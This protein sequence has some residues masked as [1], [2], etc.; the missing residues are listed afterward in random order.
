MHITIIR[1]YWKEDFSI[2]YYREQLEKWLKY[3]DVKADSVLD[4]GGLALPV[5]NRVKSW[6][7][8]EYKI[9]DNGAESTEAPDYFEDLNQDIRY[10]LREFDVVFCLEVFEYIWNPVQAMTNL[11]KYVKS[12]GGILY[13]SFPTNYP[14]HNPQ[15]IDYL[16]YT[17]Y[18]VEKLL[19]QAGFNRWEI[20]P[21]VATAHQTLARFWQ[22]EAMHPMKGNPEIYDL[23]YMVKAWKE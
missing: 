15:G 11:A 2:S 4:V 13:I 10:F 17:K 12:N 14:L 22:E 8:E 7:V 20:T 23:G 16:R 6:E 9:L 1:D 19:S 5:K 21:R 18:A 3:I